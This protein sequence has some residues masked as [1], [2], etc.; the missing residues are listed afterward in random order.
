MISDQ[1]REILKEH[2]EAELQ[3]M[4]ETIDALRHAVKAVAPDNALGRLTRMDAI[5]D[6]NV[7]KA[8][9]SQVLERRENLREARRRLE[10]DGF[11][12]CGVCERPISMDRLLAVPDARVCMMCYQRV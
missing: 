1:D 12:R 11:G 3:D 10:T 5:G 8:K 7:A 2:I 6:Q 4:E 9:L